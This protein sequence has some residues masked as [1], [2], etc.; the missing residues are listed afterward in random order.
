MACWSWL[1]C[2]SQ[3]R[4]P[5]GIEDIALEIKQRVLRIDTEATRRLLN[6]QQMIMFIESCSGGEFGYGIWGGGVLSR[7]I[8]LCIT[9][10]A[11][12]QKKYFSMHTFL[13]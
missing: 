5:V 1:G 7:I 9:R 8:H 4:H 12:F 3:G 10:V 6:D 13:F 2:I 11:V